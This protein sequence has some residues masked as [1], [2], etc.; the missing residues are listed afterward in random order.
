LM[1]APGFLK[2]GAFV[3]TGEEPRTRVSS[4]GRLFPEFYS[5]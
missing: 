3:F 5:R 4:A 1:K 2:P